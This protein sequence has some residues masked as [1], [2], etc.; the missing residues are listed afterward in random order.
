M[1]AKKKAQTAARKENGVIRKGLSRD[2]DSYKVS[3]NVK[4]VTPAGKDF[5]TH[6]A[7]DAK[8]LGKGAAAA[9]VQN[10]KLAAPVSKSESKANARGLKAANAPIKRR[11]QPNK[12]VK[13]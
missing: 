11:V 3:E 7:K 13:P 9:R 4:V 12:K 10:A 6:N 2:H 8:G 1:F 5:L